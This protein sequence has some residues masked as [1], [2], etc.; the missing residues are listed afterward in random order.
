MFRGP[1]PPTSL[2]SPSGYYCEVQLTLPWLRSTPER[3]APAPRAP[4]AVTIDGAHYVVD[5]ARHARARRY[6]LR[7]AASGR[8]RLTVPRGASIGGGLR[9]VERQASWIAREMHRQS[10][11]TAVWQAGAFVWYRGLRVPITETDAGV[12][13]GDLEMPR[14]AGAGDLRRSIEARLRELA[15][16]ELPARCARLAEE[17]GLSVARVS[18]RNQ[19]SRW[20]SCSARRTIALNWRLV[21]MPDDVRDY[22]I[23]HELMHLRQPNH[24]RRF[25][26]EVQGVCPAWR[27]AERWLHQ[28]GKQLL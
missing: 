21:Q 18:V 10:Q 1:A 19:R 14:P 13:V 6:V 24:S 16:A 2:V 11:R 17:C 4:H 20:G 15:N 23:F 5:I 26:R 28:F 7:L 12:A 8:L 9:F 22:V 27:D 3:Q 25:W